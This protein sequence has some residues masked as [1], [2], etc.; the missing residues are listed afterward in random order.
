MTKRDSFPL[1]SLMC[2]LC[3][4]PG[5]PPVLSEIEIEGPGLNQLLVFDPARSLSAVLSKSM[6]L[7]VAGVVSD[8]GPHKSDLDLAPSYDDNPTRFPWVIDVRPEP[9]GRNN[10]QEVRLRL[11]LAVGVGQSGAALSPDLINEVLML[12]GPD[13]HLFASVSDPAN[14]PIDPQGADA[15]AERLAAIEAHAQQLEAQA[16]QLRGYL[17]ICERTLADFAGRA[18]AECIPLSPQPPDL[19]GLPVR[20]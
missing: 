18:R 15:V 14:Q 2:N 13:L 5:K 11:T 8:L 3:V 9:P 4:M 12:T 6:A 16:T 17:A 20:T 7:T 10:R 1:T 19:R